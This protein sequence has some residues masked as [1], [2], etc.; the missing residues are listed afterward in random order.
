M[1]KHERRAKLV[2]AES[3]KQCFVETSSEEVEGPSYTSV[4]HE[5]HPKMYRTQYSTT[6]KLD[7]IIVSGRKS[8]KLDVNITSRRKSAK[9]DVIIVS[10]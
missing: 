6:A 2:D 1:D 4:S 7:V 8:A 10:R 3:H 5:H 9:M